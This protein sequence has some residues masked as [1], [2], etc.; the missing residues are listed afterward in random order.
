MD[1]WLDDSPD[2]VPATYSICHKFITVIHFIY[3]LI[4]FSQV[5][6]LVHG[7]LELIISVK[8]C[9][10]RSIGIQPAVKDISVKAEPCTACR[11]N[12]RFSFSLDMLQDHPSNIWELQCYISH[13]T[14]HQKLVCG[15]QCSQKLTLVSVETYVG[16]AYPVFSSHT[17]Y[18]HSPEATTISATSITSFTSSFPY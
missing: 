7:E 3:L 14:K 8:S 15:F 10:V 2:T 13:C 12:N 5:S 1:L 18:V 6:S 17:S 4:L 9:V 16:V 11:N